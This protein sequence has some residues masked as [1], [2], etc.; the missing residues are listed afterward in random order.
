MI[1]IVV[2]RADEASVHIGERLLEVADWTASEDASHPPGEGG[3]TYRHRD[4]FELRHFDELHLH[5]VDV[6]EVFDQPDLVVFVSRHAG[7]TGPL[8]TAHFTGN[9]GPAEYGGRPNALARAAPNAHAAVLDAL[10]RHAPDGYEVGMECTHHGP[11]DV[12]APSLFVEVG[13]AEAQWRDPTAAAA[14]ARSVLDLA[15]V[16]P[17]R[18]RTVVGLGGGH[19][20]PRFE[21]VVRETDW[22]VGHVVADWALEAVDQFPTDLLAAVFERSG[23][24]RALLDGDRPDLAAAIEALGHDVVSETWIRETTGVPLGV[25][26]RAEAALCSVEDG[27]RFGQRT[28]P[29]VAITVRRLHP[30]LVEASLAANT[31]ATR[32]TIAAHAVAYETAE[33]GNRPTG[34]VGLP[35]GEALGRLV[36]DLAGVLRDDGATVDRDDDA[37]VVTT[38]VFDPDR[39][40]ELGVPEGPAFGRLTAGE[41]VEVDGETVE[42]AT[43][44]VD[45]TERYPILAP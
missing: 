18:D 17:D 44:H 33:N 31:D 19:Y 42:P 36:D 11:T 32:A 26:E 15:D 2:S 3:G 29:E 16:A 5:L 45:R 24:G 37:L 4:G 41:P 43:V 8:L 23:A 14:V 40:R 21:R 39:A 1:G 13:S 34:C 20:A 27:L 12:G 9:V 30:D 10:D 25:V 35:G 22:A 38:S 7:E 28:D 6:A